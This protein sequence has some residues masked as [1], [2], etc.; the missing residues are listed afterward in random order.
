MSTAKDEIQQWIDNGYDYH[1]GVTIL[2]KYGNKRAMV[3][4]LEKGEPNASKLEHLKY[5]VL[6]LVKEVVPAKTDDKFEVEELNL[7]PDDTDVETQKQK[8]YPEEVVKLKA[9]KAKIYTDRALAHKELVEVGTSND[10]DSVAK[11]KQLRDTIISLT[12]DFKS[13]DAQIQAIFDA[14]SGKVPAQQNPEP[15]NNDNSNQENGLTPAAVLELQ[16]EFDN[17]VAYISKNK[18]TTKPATQQKVEERKAR[19]EEI[20]KLLEGI[21]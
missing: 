4:F 3:K 10:A 5:N 12:D 11:R 15:V 6:K 8:N 9:V 1:T 2:R 14:L 7:R 20:K 16:K 13:T 18:N 21:E 19:N 17:N